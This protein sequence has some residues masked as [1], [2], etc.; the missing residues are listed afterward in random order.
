MVFHPWKRSKPLIEVLITGKMRGI[1]NADR[2]MAIDRLAEA[3]EKPF[4]AP[5][6]VSCRRVCV[7]ACVHVYVSACVHACIRVC[8]HAR[9]CVYVCVCVCVCEKE[10][11]KCQSVGPSV[12]QSIILSF[13]QCHLCYC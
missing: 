10:R 3:T 11:K 9:A 6:Y 5:F 8:V 4:L 7:R 12:N 1:N 2:S 13:Y